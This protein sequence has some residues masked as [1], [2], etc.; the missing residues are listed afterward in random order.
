M[1]SELIKAILEFGGLG[2]AVLT[3]LLFYKFASEHVNKNTESLDK[4]S[5]Y[6][7]ENTKETRKNIEIMTEFKYIIKSNGNKICDTQ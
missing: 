6:I 2:V 5:G 7:N 4:L 3:I 1:S